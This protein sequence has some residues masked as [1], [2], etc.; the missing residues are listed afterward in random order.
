MS[1]RKR[2]TVYGVVGAILLLMV[3][4]YVGAYYWMVHPPIPGDETATPIFLKKRMA[5]PDGGY[6]VWHGYRPTLQ[7]FFTPILWIDRRIRPS[8][9]EP[10]R[11]PRAP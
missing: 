4:G 9:W 3:S 8:Y 6:M 7:K 5:H 11:E 1:E 2:S 10:T